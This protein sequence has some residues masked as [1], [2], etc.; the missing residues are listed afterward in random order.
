[1]GWN[2]V[3]KRKSSPLLEGIRDGEFFY[4]VHSYFV[5]PKDE[6]V[7]LTESDYGIRFCSSVEKENIFATQFHPEK[8]QRAGLKLLENFVKLV[9]RS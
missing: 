3:F 5:K 1:M 6:S 9:A 4:F 7:V 8:S 2:Q